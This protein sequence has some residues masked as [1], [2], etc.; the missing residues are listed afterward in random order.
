MRYPKNRNEQTR[1]KILTSA[2]ALFAAR[3][4]D[5]VSIDDVMRTCSLTRG[6]FYAHF[7]SKGVLYREAMQHAMLH[8]HLRLSV[9][10]RNRSTSFEQKLLTLIEECIG[11]QCDENAVSVRLAFLATDLMSESPDVREFYSQAMAGLL[12]QLATSEAGQRER[13][14]NV[15]TA[16]FAMVVGVAAIVRSVN[17]RS[18]CTQFVAACQRASAILANS[19][20]EPSSAVLWD[21]MYGVGFRA[22]AN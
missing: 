6:G 9:S 3:G 11:N 10:D 18:T 21:G 22:L 8:G 15:S 4:F 19:A 1:T 12:A 7:R 17:D 14:D 2:Y 16:A 13:D 20:N 5:A